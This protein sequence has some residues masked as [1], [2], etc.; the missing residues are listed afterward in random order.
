[1]KSVHSLKDIFVQDSLSHHII[2]YHEVGFTRFVDKTYYRRAFYS[3]V[4][5]YNRAFVCAV[6]GIWAKHGSAVLQVHHCISPSFLYTPCSK[7]WK[8]SKEHL[9]I[10][11]KRFLW[12]N[13]FSRAL[14]CF[15]NMVFDFFQ[16]KFKH[17]LSSAFF[18]KVFD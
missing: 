11:I 2:R 14:S 17:R 13:C 1:M 12:E 9:K 5:M 10:A 18:L 4:V 15:I 7:T 8:Q 3:V 16:R 6:S